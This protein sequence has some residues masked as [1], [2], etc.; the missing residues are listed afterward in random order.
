MYSFVH[1]SIQNNSTLINIVIIKLS[2]SHTSNF[3]MLNSILIQKCSKRVNYSVASHHFNLK[4][5]GQLTH[6]FIDSQKSSTPED[7]ENSV[8]RE[9]TLLLPFVH[10]RV[11]LLINEL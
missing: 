11:N 2:S 4:T 5:Y 1:V 8:C 3:H 7:L 10:K 6:R 9:L